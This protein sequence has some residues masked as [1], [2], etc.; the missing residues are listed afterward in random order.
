MISKH[1][2]A[3][4]ER[5]WLKKI[6]KLIGGGKYYRHKYF[7]L[8]SIHKPKNNG[9]SGKTRYR[10]KNINPVIMRVKCSYS[11]E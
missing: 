7:F 4:R 3:H 10:V 1:T 2:H 8:F 9:Y 6:T 5:G 11:T